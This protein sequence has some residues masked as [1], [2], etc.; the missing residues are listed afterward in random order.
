[1]KKARD[2]TEHWQRRHEISSGLWIWNLK[3]TYVSPSITEALGYTVE[4]ILGRR[5]MDLLT[6]ASIRAGDEELHGRDAKRNT[7]S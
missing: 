2:A 6:P 7:T 4:E 5:S 1:L 3:Y